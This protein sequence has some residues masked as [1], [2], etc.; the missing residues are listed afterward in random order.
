MFN[1]LK[2]NK[3]LIAMSASGIHICI[4]SVYAWSVL[5]LPIM[6]FTQWSLFSITVTFSIAILFLGLSAGYFGKYVEK[7]GASKSGLTSMAFF[8]TGILGSALSLY[9]Q[10]VYLLYLF[11]GV[12][13]GIG[14]GIGYITPISTLVKYFPNNRG[15]ATGLAIMSFGFASM[16][17]APL[18]NHLIAEYGLITNFIIMALF[19][20]VIMTVSSL[21]L[22]SP[23]Y[24]ER[25]D[26]LPPAKVY[27]TWQFKALWH[28]FFVNI[29]CGI[30]LL[31]IISPMAQEVLS[32]SAERAAGL[33]GIIGLVNG[34]GRIFWSTFSDYVGR[35]NVYL[36]FF[37]VQIIAFFFLA[38]TTNEFIFEILILAI[39]SC[40]G[41]GFSCM[42]AYLAD[43]F[44]GKHL[45]QIHGRVLTAWAFA[46]IAGPIMIALG[47][48]YLGS[49]TFILYAFCGLFFLNLIVAYTLKERGRNL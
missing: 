44:G 14:L 1:K 47:K 13:S 29:A 10:N 35:N 48:Q 25:G 16:I 30:A 7:Y 19:Y 43:I 36:L 49:Y 5:V 4:G 27:S 33:V 34:F 6:N 46:G 23:E 26:S 41:G 21:Y 28:I 45:S 39:I 9:L 17:A 18:M 42:P 24:K 2:R 20:S 37:I 40:Y 31:S 38:T 32:F 12:L 11:Y 8:V 3:W 22:D 15:F